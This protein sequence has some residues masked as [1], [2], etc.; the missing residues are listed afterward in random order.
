M[1]HSYLEPEVKEQ[2]MRIWTMMFVLLGWTLAV[3]AAPVEKPTTAPAGAKAVVVQLEGEINDYS[4]SDLVRRLDQAKAMGATA[5]ILEIDSWGGAVTAGLETSRHLK[6]R[7]DMYIVAFVKQKAISAGA[8][9]ALACN[10][11]WMAPFSSLGD[12]APIIPS[13]TGGLENVDPT[14]RAK[15]ESPVVEDFRDSAQRNGYNTLLVESMVVVGR[16]VYFVKNK[17]GEKRFVDGDEYKKL[18]DQ[19]WEPVIPDR[20]PVDSKESLLT[21]NA[22]VAEQVGLAKGLVYSAEEVAGKFGW[23]VIGR[24]DRSGGDQ[25]IAFLSSMSVR[26]MLITI[27]VIA[28]YMSFN[29]PGHGLAEVA[30]VACLALLLGVPL[31]T[32]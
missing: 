6:Q 14:N 7:G 4:Y 21:V 29:A 31:M 9:I 3:A 26:S 32:G 19:G 22:T 27:L 17:A 2:A 28:I 12:A 11:I 18:K 13:P 5:V 16:E 8:M 10:S 24:L 20:N 15:M 25:L 23:Q 1:L 30:V